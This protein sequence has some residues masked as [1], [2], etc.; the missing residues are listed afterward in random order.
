MKK[1]MVLIAL[2]MCFL[3]PVSNAR[4]IQATAYT[5]T[6]STDWTYIKTQDAYLPGSVMLREAGLLFPEDIDILGNRMYIADTGNARILLYR[7]DTGEVTELGKGLLNKPTGVCAGQDGRVYVADYGHSEVLVFDEAGDFMT[8]IGRPENLI[9]G[10][11]T[12][13]KPQKL[14]VDGFGNLYVLSEGTHEGILQFDVNGRFAGFF[15]ANKTGAL[16]VLEW[17]QDRFYTQ[18]QKSKLF[19]RN[20][21]RYVNLAVDQNNLIYPL[22]PLQENNAVQTLNLAGVNIMP[23]FASGAAGYVDVAL[24]PGGQIITVTDTGAIFEHSSWG[25]YLFAF[26]GRAAQADRNGLTSVVSA[27]AVDGEGNLFV[28]DKQRGVLQPYRPTDFANQIHQGLR[29]YDQGRYGEA[30]DIWR[31]FLRLSPRANFAH[32]GYG[33]AMWQLGEYALAQYHLEKA[34]DSGY[35]SDAFWE[36]RNEWLMANLPGLLT[37][38]LALGILY[39]LLHA[40]NKRWRFTRP[41][42]GAWLRLKERS[43]L[44]ADLAFMRHMV[45]HPLDSYYDLKHGA[46]G[47]VLSASVLYLLALLVWLLDQICTAPLFNTMAFSFSWRNPLVVTGV[48]VVPAVLFVIGNYFISSINDGEGTFKNVYI[49]M[50]Y[51]LSLFIL[52]L[53]L[54]TLLSYALTMN[55]AFVHTLLRAVILGYTAVLIFLS[56]K[57]THAYSAGAA[58][59]NLL[60][61]ALFVVLCAMAIAILYMV[62]NELYWFAASLFEEVRFIV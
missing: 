19:G 1:Q 56:A 49:A 61:T 62:F 43:P 51:A 59:K 57:E 60:L 45:K 17:I 34:G 14:A 32:W 42:K 50:A 58:I 25:W 26:G 11:S 9:Y 37:W 53:P 54:T 48:A 28:L 29:L 22:T 33:L 30:A 38:L 46:R 41:V 18:E 10:K 52:T 39:G 36:R 47:S 24:T 8:R 44:I 13:Y 6:V 55:E 31:E 5:Y 23:Y 2:L 12:A 40:L 35:A 16:S 3:M 27:I 15:G 21:P 4:A 20:P 7:M